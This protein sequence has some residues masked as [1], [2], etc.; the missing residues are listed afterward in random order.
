[1]YFKLT[2]P[3]TRNMLKV[4]IWAN[5]TPK[6][7]L[8]HVCTA[9]HACKQ[10]GLDTKEANAPMVLEV[11][12]CELD[13]AKMEYTKLARTTKKKTKERKENDENPAPGVQKKVKEPKEKGENP[14]PEVNINTSTL[15]TAKKAHEEAAKKVKEVKLAVSM[16]GAMPFELY[17]H[18]LSDK[19]RQ[20]LEK[21]IKAQVM[22]APWEVI[23][24]VPQP[25]L[26]PKVGILSVNASNF[27]FKTCFILMQERP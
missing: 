24:G 23:F 1:M 12:Y 7:C 16:A 10:I 19:A 25:R 15:A 5:G 4:A 22:Q 13:A 21:V 14:A 26:P 20:P 27:N 2:L 8:V 17:R 3:N 6:Q 11:A 9:M 18:L